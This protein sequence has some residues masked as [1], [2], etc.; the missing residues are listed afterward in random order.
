[1][2]TNFTV[3]LPEQLLAQLRPVA[4]FEEA[5]F[6]EAHQHAAAVSVRQH[7]VKYRGLSALT[8][9]VPWCTN[10]R[11][12]PERPVFTLD[13]AFHSGAYYVQEAS[14]MFLEQAL[15]AIGATSKKVKVLDLCAA[16]GGKSTHIAS[17]MQPESLLI[18]NLLRATNVHAFLIG[19][20][21]LRWI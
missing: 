15:I 8:D 19:N 20:P 14:S 3:Q 1:M 12:L 13:P 21:I 10:G 17:L 4:G 18:S 11:Y 6:V 9:A 16:P 5:S 7:P 2:N